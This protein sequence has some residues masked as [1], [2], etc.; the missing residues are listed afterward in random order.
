LYF[1]QRAQQDR[2]RNWDS[3]IATIEDGRTKLVGQAGG[4]SGGRMLYDV[5]VLAKFSVNGAEQERWIRVE[6]VARGLSAVQSQIGWWKGKQCF[7]RW[8]ASEP[9]RI[10][11]EVN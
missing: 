10:E 5:E 6:Q 3:A 9:E 7:V 11:V 4:N 1:K 8:K 2:E